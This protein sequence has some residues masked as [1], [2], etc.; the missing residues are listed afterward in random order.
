MFS[1]EDY[2]GCGFNI[3]SRGRRL[4]GLGRGACGGRGMKGGCRRVFGVWVWRGN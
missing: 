2:L 4:S 1:F 3:D